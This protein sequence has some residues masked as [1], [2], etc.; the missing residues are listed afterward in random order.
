MGGFFGVITNDSEV[1]AT[2]LFYGTD[3]HCHLGI[4]RGG[5]VTVSGSMFTRVI[6]DITNTQ[7]RSKFDSDL[8]KL[9]G[10]AGIGVISDYEDQPLIIGSHLGTYA[11]VTVGAIKNDVELTQRAFNKRLTHFSEMSGNEL[12]ATE[13]TAT[14]INEEES[15]EAGIRAAQEKIEG[16]MSM[17]ILT[18]K[19]I[20]AVRDRLGRTPVVIGKGESGYAVTMETCAFYNLG[21]EVEKEL[22]PG[23]VVFITKDGYEQRVAPGDKMQICTFL[24]IYYGYPASDYEGI[25]VERSRYRCGAALAARDNVEVDF[26]AGIPDS[27]V[28]HA[29]GYAQKKKISYS[30]PFVKYTPTWA[31][32]FLPP[33]QAARELVAK[34]K[35]I[36]VKKLTEGKKILFCDDSLVRGTQLKDTLQRLYA[37]G[38]E[39]IHMRLACPPLFFGC[40]YLNFS[41]SKSE[42]DLAT[43]K[44]IVTMEGSDKYNIEE[45]V[46]EES[47]KHHAMIEYIRS[48]M[49]LTSLAFQ[50]LNDMIEAI[51]I[52]G[53]NMCTY[54]WTGCTGCG[55]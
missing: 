15:F 36:P 6:H 20:Y 52:P 4:R 5:L 40:N 16:S 7:F 24:W 17:L 53:G 49:G 47:D 55:K 1:C 22:G 41:R 29:L 13:L 28:A 44:A 31:R 27:G 54:C 23:E 30:R 14:L 26:A 12:N 25:N 33:N 19:G 8:D 3:Y 42:M 18:P 43:R 34:M 50:R 21:Y 2:R 51:D 46:N 9:N 48:G 11:I 35:L 37:Y 38:A 10:Q 32:S 45:Y 39:E